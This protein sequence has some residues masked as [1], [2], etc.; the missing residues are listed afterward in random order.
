M[1]YGVC[2]QGPFVHISS[3]VADKMSQIAARLDPSFSNEA[4]RFENLA[5][6]CAV[7]VACTFSAPVGG[8]VLT[9]RIDF[10]HGQMKALS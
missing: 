6:A 9:A 4:R 7:G 10:A 5:A 8:T 2:V 3:V 1:L